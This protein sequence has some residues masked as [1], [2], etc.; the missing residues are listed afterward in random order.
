MKKTLL[1]DEGAFHHI[2][3][4]RGWGSQF[5]EEGVAPHTKMRTVMLYTGQGENRISFKRVLSTKSKREVDYQLRDM[6]RIFN[7]YVIDRELDNYLN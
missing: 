1:M 3:L 2:A 7:E 5:K 4:L 6:L